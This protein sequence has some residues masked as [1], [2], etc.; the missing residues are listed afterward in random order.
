[1]E[2]AKVKTYFCLGLVCK[3]IAGK[4]GR[5]FDLTAKKKRLA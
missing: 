4:A 5:F 2:Q 3:E 1:M